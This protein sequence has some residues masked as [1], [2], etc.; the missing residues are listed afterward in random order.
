MYTSV[1]YFFHT[2]PLFFRFIRIIC[3]SSLLSLLLNMFHFMTILQLFCVRFGC[4]HLLAIMNKAAVNIYAQFL[5]WTYITFL[6]GN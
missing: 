5:V 4:F 6:L 3:I 2:A 1:S